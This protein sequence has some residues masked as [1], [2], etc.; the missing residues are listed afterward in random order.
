MVT[1]TYSKDGAY[2][3]RCWRAGVVGWCFH[4]GKGVPFGS[5][6]H[7]VTVW[8]ETR[9]ICK[10]DLGAVNWEFETGAYTVLRSGCE[11]R[12][13][14]IE[15]EHEDVPSAALIESIRTH[16]SPVPS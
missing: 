14:Q 13:P 15:Y 3:A 5:G 16:Q 8:S 10:E 1:T 2:V 9:L 7:L 4:C 12:R 11:K 6:W